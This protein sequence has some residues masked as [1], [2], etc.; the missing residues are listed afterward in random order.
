M[1]P[2]HHVAYVT[3]FGR[4][5]V[6]RENHPVLNNAPL[7]SKATYTKRGLAF[8]ETGTT[9]NVSAK[10][11]KSY[12][13]PSL[14]NENMGEIIRHNNIKTRKQLCSFAKKTT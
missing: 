3:K 4:H 13:A 11:Q 10:K 6:T 7:T 14:K 2:T 12:T 8:E 1:Q 5:F 9:N